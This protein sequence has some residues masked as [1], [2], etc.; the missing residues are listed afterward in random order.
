MP[1]LRKINLVA[2]IIFTKLYV[3]LIIVV[4]AKDKEKDNDKSD[5]FQTN[6]PSVSFSKN[7][8][9]LS[10]SETLNP[11]NSPFR[12]PSELLN[13][14]S[15]PYVSTSEPV[16]SYR[17]DQQVTLTDFFIELSSISTLAS[18]SGCG[19]TMDEVLNLANFLTVTKKHLGTYLSLSLSTG[20]YTY[21]ALWLVFTGYGKGND[22][23]N[24]RALREITNYDKSKYVTKHALKF[25]C[26][27]MFSD[28]P[29]PKASD[30]DNLR[31]EALDMSQ[32]VKEL[33]DT[34]NE[35][36]KSPNSIALLG[37]T[38]NVLI[39]PN[40][41][42][43]TSTMTKVT[44][45]PSEQMSTTMKAAIGGAI[46]A[47]LVG[48]V[49]LYI[50]FRYGGF[51]PSCWPSRKKSFKK[52]KISTTKKITRFSFIPHSLPKN[53]TEEASMNDQSFDGNAKNNSISESSIGEFDARSVV[54]YDGANSIM[55]MS[56]TQSMA[57]YS[58]QGQSV[59]GSSKHSRFGTK[60]TCKDNTRKEMVRLCHLVK[61]TTDDDNSVISYSDIGARSKYNVQGNFLGNHSMRIIDGV[62]S[63]KSNSF[64]IHSCE[65]D[66]LGENQVKKDDKF[67]EI[68]QL[69]DGSEGHV[70][71]IPAQA[72]STNYLYPTIGAA[73]S[74]AIRMKPSSQFD[75]Q[76]TSSKSQNGMKS[77]HT[78]KKQSEYDVPFDERSR[79]GATTGSLL[80]DE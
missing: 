13:I 59:A 55:G 5:T 77:E 50:G 20:P 4:A 40:G 80:F 1:D 58:V 37:V 30:L 36:L 17:I 11:S 46:F 43:T 25:R 60:Y 48:A 28:G 32:Y 9:F 23:N 27:A 21:G 71:V 70:E 67:D 74:D 68:W 38:S 72:R 26:M 56:E 41:A 79:R 24:C 52:D 18:L 22:H 33:T 29:V 10:S 15:R 62:D 7:S 76:H 2:L 63:R 39:N 51:G 54:S 45:I 42:S 61:D 75:N 64:C 44:N 78:A 73:H 12:S 34:K 53:S 35:V 57:G 66:T 65:A 69:D 3:D 47:I 6:N 31:K 49:M 14:D 16:S 8:T 19:S